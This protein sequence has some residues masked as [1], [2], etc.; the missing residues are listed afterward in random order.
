MHAYQSVGRASDLLFENSNAVE[1]Q[2]NLYG[3]TWGSTPSRPKYLSKFTNITISIFD[4][5]EYYLILLHP[6]SFECA[7]IISTYRCRS[8][9][10][11]PRQ[12]EGVCVHESIISVHAYGV[13]L[14]AVRIRTY[15]CLTQS[16]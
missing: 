11:T 12:G 5:R 16:G 15:Q 3:E 10:F 14:R 7:N 6:M 1:Y 2:R 8:S 9:T 13:Q 4:R